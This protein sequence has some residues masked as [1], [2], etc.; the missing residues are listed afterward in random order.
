M[1][2]SIDFRAWQDSQ[3]VK[4]TRAEAIA[5]TYFASKGRFYRRTETGTRRVSLEEWIAVHTASNP[6]LEA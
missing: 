1:S 4:A 6:T 2:K 3:R 5:H